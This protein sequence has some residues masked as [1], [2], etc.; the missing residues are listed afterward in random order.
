MIE[1][2]DYRFEEQVYASAA[3]VVSRAKRAR[4]GLRVVVKQ[5]RDECPR[6][7]AIERLRREF[8]ILERLRIPQVARA[9]SLE[10]VGSSIALVLEDSDGE[11]V[12]AA[13]QRPGFDSTQLVRVALA[14]SRAVHAIHEKG[15]I[16]K[17]LKPAHM[18]LE[19]SGA[20][21]LIDFGISID[22]RDARRPAVDPD[23]LEGTLAYISPEQTGRMSRTVDQRSDLYSLGISL[24][25]LATGQRPFQSTDALELVHAHIAKTP[26]RADAVRPGTPAVLAS[27]IDKLLAKVPEDRYQTAAGLIWDLERCLRELEASGTLR[28]FELGERDLSDR[29]QLPRKIYGRELALRRLEAAFEQVRVGNTRLLLL[30]GPSGVGKSAVVHHLRQ[31]ARAPR[32]HFVSGKFDQLRSSTPYPALSEACRALMR[33][34]LREPAEGLA[35]RREALLG[36]LGANAAVVADVVPELELIVGPQPRPPPLGPAEAQGRFEQAME[37][38][39]GAVVTA[40]A[41]LVLFLDDVQWADAPSLRLLRRIVTAPGH[42]PLLVLA[43]YRDNEVST[44]QPLFFEL[45]QLEKEAP[46]VVA[47]LHLGPLALEDV[48][49]LAADTL[50]REPSEVGPLTKVLFEKTHGNPFHLGQFLQAIHRDGLLRPDPSQR[51]WVWDLEGIEARRA[52][53]NVIELVL[54]RLRALPLAAQRVLS[55]AACFGHQLDADTLAQVAELEP[56][57]LAIGLEASLRE[58]MLLPLADGQE[59]PNARFQFLHDRVQ[60]AAY[61]LID[62]SQRQLVHLKVGRRLRLNLGSAPTDGQLYAVA[63]QMNRG[64]AHLDDPEE[65]LWLAEL[66]LSCAKKAQASAATAIALELLDR[67]LELASEHPLIGFPAHLAKAECE[68]LNGDHAKAFASI[69]FLDARATHLVDR[70]AAANLRILV[71]TSLGRFEEACRVSATT[72]RLLGLEIPDPDDKPGLG[73]A[74]GA[75][76]GALQGELGAREVSALC[77]L[78]EMTDPAHLA[79]LDVLS[80][81]IPPAYQENQALMVLAVLKGVR[82]S[83]AHGAGDATPF[84]LAQ[85]AIAHMAI[86]GDLKAAFGF[87]RTAVDLGHSRHNPAAMGPAHFLFA[88]FTSHWCEPV[89]RSEEH[90]ALGLRHCLEAGDLLHASYCIGLGTLYRIHAGRDL[91][92]LR[93]DLPALF[94]MVDRIGDVTNRALLTLASRFIASLS[95]P[96]PRPGS[97]DGEGIEDATLNAANKTS[98]AWLLM[99]RIVARFHAGEFSSVLE[100]ASGEKPLLGLISIVDFEFYAGL[101][102]AA[103][104]RQTTGAERDH[105]VEHLEQHLV[106][107]RKWA[108]LCPENHAHRLALLTAEL[109]DLRGDVATA[110]DRYEE[111]IEGARSQGFLQ[112][113]AVACELYGAFHLRA[114]R[115]RAARPSLVDAVRAYERWGATAKAKRLVD[116]HASLDLLSGVESPQDASTAKRTTKLPTIGRGSSLTLDLESAMRA[117]QAIASEL[118]SDKLLDR[119]LRIVVENAGAQRGVLLRPSAGELLIEAVRTVEPDEVR[120]RLGGRLSDTVEAPAHL[121]RY[122]A[123]TRETVVSSDAAIDPTFEGDAYL[124]QRAPK[125]VLCLPLLHQGQ[126]IAVLYLENASTPHVFSPTRVTRIQFLAAHAASA[127]ENSRLFEEVQGARR[128]LESRVEARTKE[129]S[130]RNSDLRGV[131]DAVSQGLVTIDRDGRVEGEVSAKAMAWFGP[132]VQGGAWA[133]ALARIDPDFSQAFTAR[134][135]QL[136][137]GTATLQADAER[138]PRRLTIKGRTLSLELRPVGGWAGWTRL[139]VVASD[140]TD[141]ERQKQLELELRHAQKLESVG[142]LA[143]GIAHEIN[144]PAQFVGDSLSFLADSFRDVQQVLAAYRQAVGALPLTPEATAAREALA[145]TEEAADLAFVEEQATPAFERA[146]DGI[147]RIATLVGAMKEF[148][149]PDRREKS[150]AD[151]NR[152]LRNTLTIAHNEYKTVAEVETELGELPLVM[153][154]LSDM[155]QVFLN[156]LINAAQAVADTVGHT[157]KKGRIVVRT[158][159]EAGSVRISIEDSGCG[160]PEAIRDRIFDPFFTTKEVGRGSGQGLAIARSIVVD[161][162]G[163]TLTFEST[164]GKGT[165][166]TVVLPVGTTVGQDLA[167]PLAA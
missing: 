54:E 91:E 150:G 83:L 138:L 92:A 10:P 120:L 55:V 157:G 66:D 93:A 81:T 4:D 99:L 137:D 78:P 139:L 115:A 143:A 34:L 117:T 141:E 44:L 71:L 3:T 126:L 74:I 16:H 76:F 65:R 104:A 14:I 101:A 156:L 131:L 128:E 121:V 118:E 108:T 123:R 112:N 142:Q 67:A 57:E 42:R 129:L 151:L 94:K 100:A 56:G 82:L 63:Q 13:A 149:H 33:A 36:A 68:Y 125:S 167:R 52:T 84:F 159:Q 51:R 6:R 85:Y 136:K 15:V 49:Q 163:G 161:K 48:T 103:L 98:R 147:S 22:L 146:Q 64:L 32:G 105:H 96:S 73:Q 37:R 12:D 39:F 88:A 158:K 154:H 70:V 27:I 25:E 160:I 69:D 109:A 80:R 41:P 145:R 111:A 119:L 106:P 62:E 59:G 110:L 155:N 17:D 53:D 28:P 30:A 31:Q 19:P 87:A 95:G 127:L 45:K 75:E 162:H 8:A 47:T 132:I 9:I 43:A 18:L 122:V 152:A 107:L 97:L 20:V 116:Q 135:A 5:P 1:L 153:C 166:F 35:S 133:E 89:A 26:P 113:H 60:Q 21:T 58:G 61:A 50:H 2:P 124:K 130:R 7:E 24:F 164:V 148:A 134:L 79:T 90:F 86:T 165:T 102:H 77:R 114:G 38:F 40:D 23:L 72:L 11:P 144:T 46:G 140:V 29:L